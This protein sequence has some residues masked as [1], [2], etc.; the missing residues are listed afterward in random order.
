MQ[1]DMLSVKLQNAGEH[2][3]KVNRKAYRE[4]LHHDAITAEAPC[5]IGHT[6][7]VLP[8]KLG[9]VLPPHHV[10]SNSGSE[11]EH[12]HKKR[13]APGGSSKPEVVG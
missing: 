2:V 7:G 9:K 1:Q 5:Q 8:D 12:K 13:A 11:S 4:K 10:V 6:P 3:A